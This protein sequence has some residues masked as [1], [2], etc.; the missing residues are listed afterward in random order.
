MHPKKTKRMS[1]SVSE[2]YEADV[3]I[4]NASRKANFFMKQIFLF[5]VQGCSAGIHDFIVFSLSSFIVDKTENNQSFGST[6]E[7][8][9]GTKRNPLQYVTL[10][11][12]KA[13]QI[14]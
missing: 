2:N 6:R 9:G 14:S 8:I 5:K 4:R 10:D 11:L 13:N 1:T 7:T 12:G 3:D